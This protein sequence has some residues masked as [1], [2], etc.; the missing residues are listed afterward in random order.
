MATIQCM[1]HEAGVISRDRPAIIGADVRILHGEL[2]LM[3][4]STANRLRNAGIGEGDTVGLFMENNWPQIVLIL[5]LIRLGAVACPLHTRLPLEAVRRH[6][7]IAGSRKLIARVGESSARQLDG[8]T[9]LHPDELVSATLE[10][11]GAAHDYAIPLDRPATIVFTSGSSGHPKAAVLTYGNHYYSALGANMNIRLHSEDKWLL[12]LPLCHVGGLGIVFRCLQSGAAMVLAK[13][14][15]PLQAVMSRHRVNFIS[16]VTTQLYRLLADGIPA[17]ATEKLRAIIV[18]GGPCSPALLRQT[19]E[20]KWP[21]YASYGLTEMGSQV[22]AVRPGTPPEKQTTAGAVLRYR[23]LRLAEDGEIHVRG[24]TL[25][26]GYRERDQL[27]KPFGPGGWF[28]TGD[29]GEMD[30][31]GNLTV[32][33]RKDDLFISGGENM[34]PQE[35]EQALCSLNGIQNAWVVPKED[36]EFGHR[37]VAYIESDERKDPGEI[38]EALAAILP[39]FKIP[40]AIHAWPTELEQGGIKKSRA[41]LRAYLGISHPADFG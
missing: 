26:A 23:Q 24:S 36:A 9:L 14:K 34:Y 7:E 28:A 39:G 11:T 19:R 1:L 41:A 16:V 10:E 5:A 12:S 3:V 27:H 4:S 37:P 32:L 6:L 13:D 8:L 15:E 33:G 25:F 40:V 2:D 22:T 31:D 29:L 30:P 38:K 35:I 20:R 21:V 17:E 18:G